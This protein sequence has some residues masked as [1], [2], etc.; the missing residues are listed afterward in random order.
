ML[1]INT[2]YYYNIHI[3]NRHK[4]YGYSKTESKFFS[5]TFSAGTGHR[6]AREKLKKIM[7]IQNIVIQIFSDFRQFWILSKSSQLKPLLL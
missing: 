6:L 2:Y 5:Q 1:I 7:R 3:K 4:V